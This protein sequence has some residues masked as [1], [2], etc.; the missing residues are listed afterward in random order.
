MTPPP[1]G[2]TVHVL[3]T[4]TPA[5]TQ[6]SSEVVPSTFPQMEEDFA[7]DYGF[8]QSASE[9]L[10]PS[11]PEG[12]HW[13][14]LPPTPQQPERV[15]SPVDAVIK[16]TDDEV[17]LYHPRSHGH[18][19]PHTLLQSDEDSDDDSTDKDK[20]N[21]VQ[22]APCKKSG[23]VIKLLGAA[24]GGVSEVTTPSRVSYAGPSRE[25]T[26]VVSLKGDIE[27]IETANYALY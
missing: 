23:P 6:L 26:P 21:T 7:F 5:A 2:E 27:V 12:A 18:G 10:V 16:D 9:A 19:K 1:T 20:D 17:R 15:P 22:V 13:D 11:L 3:V 8:L 4:D 24:S 25:A 14:N